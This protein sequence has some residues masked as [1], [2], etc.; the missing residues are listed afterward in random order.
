MSEETSVTNQ[1]TSQDTATSEPKD[2]SNPEPANAADSKPPIILLHGFRGSPLG[3]ENIA[4]Q[5]RLA[6]Y[7][8]HVPSVPPFAGA[9]FL[10]VYGPDHYAEFVK[11]YIEQNHLE[12]PILIGHSMGSLV[13]A[14][15]A[16][17]YPDTINERLILLSPI[18]ER[19]SKFI[20]LISIFAVLLPKRL[21]DYVTTKYLFVSPDRQ[22]FRQALQQTH[23]CSTDHTPRA[24]EI[25]KA[26]LFSTRH[27]ITD[28]KL[29]PKTTFIA[30]EKD[31]LIKQKSTQKLAKDRHADTI[32]LKNTGHLHN[33]EQ[34]LETAAAI[35]AQLSA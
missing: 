13:A 9:E 25:V 26:S 22:L 20:S 18:S 15:T 8:V 21:V 10:N 3:L 16:H 11:S 34:P 35:L 1:P 7:I 2:V 29:P 23:L 28:F 17:R 24:R 31:R 33:Y 14:A 6:G 32:F 5:L 19:T 12:R 30:G 4:E 27:A